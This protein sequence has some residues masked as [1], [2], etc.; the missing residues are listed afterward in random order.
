M[1]LCPGESAQLAKNHPSYVQAQHILT[2]LK[3]NYDIFSRITPRLS[4]C[5]TNNIIARAFFEHQFVQISEGTVKRFNDDQLAF[6]LGHEL[7]HLLKPYPKCSI[8][9]FSGSSEPSCTDQELGKARKLEREADERGLLS[10]VMAGYQPQSIF[11]KS[12]NSEYLFLMEFYHASGMAHLINEPG[13]IYGTV[14][15]RWQ[16]LRRRALNQ[17]AQTELFRFGLV[18]LNTGEFQTAIDALTAFKESSPFGSDPYINNNLAIAWMLLGQRKAGITIPNSPII[19]PVHPLRRLK[20]FE[21]YLPDELAPGEADLLEAKTLLV[22][23]LGK[24]NQ[25]DLISYY[26]LSMVDLSMAMVRKAN[27]LFY[28]NQALDNLAEVEF[29]CQRFKPDSIVSQLVNL[30][31]KTCRDEV[32]SLRMVISRIEKVPQNNTPANSLPETFADSTRIACKDVAWEDAFLAGA[33]TGKN[34]SVYYEGEDKQTVF[35]NWK[36]GN[37]NQCYRFTSSQFTKVTAAYQN[38]W[39][40]L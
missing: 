37:Q 11:N 27:R 12:G 9:T 23:N 8:S 3:N 4:V 29:L 5:R 19:V 16:D 21:E 40:R 26:N 7:N 15:H 6:V 22:E 33:D 24:G 32:K 25:L 30:F 20:D 36:T 14:N 18:A 10:M 28:T 17:L 1:P 39:Y 2:T 38:G 31:G 34:L 35:F 13:T